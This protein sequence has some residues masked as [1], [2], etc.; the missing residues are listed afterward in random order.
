M[1]LDYDINFS[2]GLQIIA[3]FFKYILFVKELVEVIMKKTP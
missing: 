2:F 1:L 3:Y